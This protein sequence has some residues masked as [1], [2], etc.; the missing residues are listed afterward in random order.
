LGAVVVA[1]AVAQ[2]ELADAQVGGLQVGG[3]AGVVVEEL[4]VGAQQRGAGFLALPLWADSEDGQVV[5]RD[6]GRVVVATMPGSLASRWREC[7]RTTGL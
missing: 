5:V 4:V 3:R 7:S 6:A 2:V 1:V